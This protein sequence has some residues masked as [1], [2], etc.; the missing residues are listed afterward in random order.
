MEFQELIRESVAQGIVLLK[1]DCETLP[2]KASDCVSV[3]GR[4]QLDYY[5]SGTGS[6]G[7]VHIPYSVNLIDGFNRLKKEG[8]SLPSLNENLVETYRD[9]VKENPFDTG[10]GEWASE[11]WFQK[12]MLLSDELLKDAASKSEKAVVVIGRTAGEDQDNRGEKGSYYLTDDEW[13]NLKKICSYF[14]KVVVVLNVS[15][16]MDT[17]WID[18]PELSGHVTAL[19]YSWQGGMQGGSGLA[20]ILCGKKCPSGKLT[21]TIAFKLEDY[22]STKNFGISNEDIY[23]EDIFVGYRYFS[24]FAKEKVMYPFGF[25][26]SYTE[27]SQECLCYS[28]D[29]KNLSVEVKVTN[30]GKVTG[31]DVVQVYASCPQGLLGKS[32]LIL[33]DFAKTKELGAGE[34]EVLKLSFPVKNLASYDDSGVT[35]FA[36]SYVLEGGVYSLFLGKDCNRLAQIFDKNGKEFSIKETFVL[37]KL[38]QCGAPEKNFSRIKVGSQKKDGQFEIE[39]ESV[40]VKKIDLAKIIKENIPSELKK[41]SG[42]EISFSDVKKDKSLI[43]EFVAQLSDKELMTLVRGEGMMSQKVTAGIASAFGG[44][45]DSLYDRGI[46]AVGC[47]DGPSGIRLDNGKE[48]TLVPIGTL[49][50]CTWNLPLVEDLYEALGAEMIEKGIDVLL[51]PGCNIHRNPLNGRNFEYFSEDPLVSGRMAAGVCRGLSA[52]GALGTIKHLAANNREH[53]RHNENSVVSERALREIYLRPFE[54][55]IKEGGAK[56]LMT[57]YNA[58]N[59]RKSASNYELNNMILRGEWGFEGVVMSDWWAVM[60]ECANGGKSDGKA[61]SYMVRSR[62]DVYMVVPNDSAENGGFGDDLEK[63]LE[64]G[65]LTRAELQICAKDI[66]LF[67]AETNAARNPLRPLRNEI[68][69]HNMLTSVPSGAK[70]YGLEEFADEKALLGD[71][72]FEIPEDGKYEVFGAFLKDGGDTLSQS[73]TNVIINGDACGSFECRSTNG[74]VMYSVAVKLPLKKG[75]YKL[76]LEHTKPGITVKNLCVRSEN[77]LISKTGLMG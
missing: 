4:C 21:D 13:A 29:D 12:E 54:I 30:T 63:S 10:N 41:S 14:K 9:W 57:S 23:E 35:G 56:S 24:T 67:V 16:I 51:G 39:S 28:F 62:N 76:C 11:P 31:S 74:A 47:S 19:L 77:F 66:L 72:Y 48:A 27:F 40:P 59:G 44:V 64:N 17:A 15:N 71:L 1:N 70:V 61:F 50:A 3:F 42:K 52:S 20:D 69:V 5:R 60:N 53:N 65:S 25:G 33:C 68:A 36:H 2:L 26:L 75:V 18:S 38:S 73:I 55:A 22:P 37:E 32:S 49:L 46:P 6:G 7:S 8:F 58:V 34:S 43:D 45:S